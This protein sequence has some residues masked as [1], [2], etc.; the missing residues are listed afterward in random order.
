MTLIGPLSRDGVLAGFDAVPRV[1]AI[2]VLSDGEKRERVQVFSVH[3]KTR[4]CGLRRG[5]G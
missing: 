1:G 4:I 2:L 3:P 5:V